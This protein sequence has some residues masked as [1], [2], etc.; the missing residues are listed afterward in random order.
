MDEIPALAQTDVGLALEYSEKKVTI[1][2]ANSALKLA[3]SQ[4]R[5]EEVATALIRL[6]HLHFRQGPWLAR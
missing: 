1:R 3:R 6:A 4:G 5:P 2:T